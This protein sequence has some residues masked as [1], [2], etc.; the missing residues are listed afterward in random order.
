MGKSVYRR[1]YNTQG[2]NGSGSNGSESNGSGYGSGYGSG[3]AA[4]SGVDTACMYALSLDQFNSL[5]YQGAT[6]PE[7]I[8]ILLYN[9]IQRQNTTQYY[10]LICL[11]ILFLIALKMFTQ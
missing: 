6:D 10:V 9:L 4:M 5:G 1:E 8:K 11:L 2:S 3:S 7:R